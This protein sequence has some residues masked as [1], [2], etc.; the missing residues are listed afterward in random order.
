MKYKLPSKH[1]AICFGII[2]PCTRDENQHSGFC[3]L[4][5]MAGEIPGL[6]GDPRIYKTSVTAPYRISS[7]DRS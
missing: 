6:L 5:H 4:T 2:F 7:V 3:S 1:T